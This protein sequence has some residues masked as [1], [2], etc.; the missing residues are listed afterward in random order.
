MAATL[1]PLI[2]NENRRSIVGYNERCMPALLH[3]AALRDDRS[4]RL[5]WVE[6]GHS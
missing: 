4:E 2:E 3:K 5:R 1:S 6:S